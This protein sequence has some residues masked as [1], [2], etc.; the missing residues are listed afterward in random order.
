[1]ANYVHFVLRIG[2]TILPILLCITIQT[3]CGQSGTVSREKPKTDTLKEKPLAKIKNIA[4]QKIT[5]IPVKQRDIYEHYINLR[6]EQGARKLEIFDGAQERI[7]HFKAQDLIG[8]SQNQKYYAVARPQVDSSNNT[9][10]DVKIYDLFDR[11]IGEGRVAAQGS[12][13]SEDEIYPLDD[14]S[15]FIQKAFLM[16]G[17]LIFSI[18]KTVQTGSGFSRKIHIDKAGFTNGHFVINYEQQLFVI[19]YMEYPTEGKQDI[20]HF[21]WY[22]TNG[23]FLWETSLPNQRI[24]SEL[25]ISPLDANL[26]FVTKNLENTEHK[27][28]FIYNNKG[29]LSKHIP[30]YKGGLYKSKFQVV[31]GVQYVLAPSDGPFYYVI[32]LSNY[33]IINK[34][35]NTKPNSNVSRVVLY[36]D[37]IVNS[38]FYG[39]YVTGSDNRPVYKFSEQ[40][41][42][43]EDK[44]GKNTYK[45]LDIT[46][47]PFIQVKNGEL[48]LTE[49]VGQGYEIYNF[50]KIQVN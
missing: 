24:I 43:F 4:L 39:G 10:Y 33:E 35:I 16:S 37:Y 26:V 15:G 11:V 38:W 6:F 29:V 18:Y 27:H 1:M 17:G 44:N 36:N 2:I 42:C 49:M 32:D 20:T 19:S 45:N 9:Y 3:G 13:E 22:T 30:V 12:E 23:D 8:V 28:L 47:Y 5:L 7:L 46:G 21:Q 41:L 31:N 40:G 14:G 48:F 50:Y 25:Y 34:Q